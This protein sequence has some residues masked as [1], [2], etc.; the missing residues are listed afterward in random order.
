[1][2][3]SNSSAFA[4]TSAGDRA[5]LPDQRRGPLIWLLIGLA[6]A[7]AALVVWRNF[8]PQP[9]H[10]SRGKHPAVGKEFTAV[11]L[12]PLTGDGRAVT[13]AEMAGKVTLIN[14]WATW[15]G[16]CKLEFPAL[17]ELEEHFRGQRDFQFLSVSGGLDDSMLRDSTVQFLQQQRTELRTFQDPNDQTK[18]K[19]VFAAGLEGFAFPTTVLIGRDG[20]I[21]GLWIGYA[22]GDER[23]VR[24]SIEAELRGDAP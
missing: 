6:A 20:T 11:S 8:G 23:H 12:Q 24:D 19:L 3:D 14:F 22:P 2:A 9:L 5:H 13:A 1:M 17:L 10:E 16:P 7:M 4:K 21:R 18:Q 15:C